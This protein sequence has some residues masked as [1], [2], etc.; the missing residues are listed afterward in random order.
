[1]RKLLALAAFLTLLPIAALADEAKPAPAPSCGKTVAECQAVVDGQA[2]TVKARDADIAGLNAWV[3][4]LRH[5]AQL[6]AQAEDML[7]QQ[8]GK[9]AHDAAAPAK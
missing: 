9:D 6:R 3:T 1:M 4:A 5:Q 8:M 7:A 2:Q